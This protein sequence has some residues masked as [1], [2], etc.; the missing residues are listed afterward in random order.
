MAFAVLVGGEGA[1]LT[2][3]GLTTGGL[4]TGGLTTGGL[5]DLALI[6]L[7][8][9]LVDLESFLTGSLLGRTDG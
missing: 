5:N 3:A 7:V 6:E 2:T 1:V 9:L 4:A 8:A